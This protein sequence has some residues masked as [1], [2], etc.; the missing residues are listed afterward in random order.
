MIRQNAKPTTLPKFYIILD[1]FHN[2][3]LQ[4][5][6][7]KYKYQKSKIQSIKRFASTFTRTSKEWNFLFYYLCFRSRNLH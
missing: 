1:K 7:F 6:F 2:L 4:L 3:S 5:I